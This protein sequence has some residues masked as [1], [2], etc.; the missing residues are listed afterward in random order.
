ML[1]DPSKG[2]SRLLEYRLAQV[3]KPAKEHGVKIITNMGAVNPQAAVAKAVEIA[4]EQGITG[5]KFAA[6]TG[7]SVYETLS[8]YGDEPI[9]EFE[10]KVGQWTDRIVSANAYMGAEGIIEALKNGADVVI[11]GRVSDP[12]LTL[13]PL[14]Y[15]YGWTLDNPEQLGQCVL[16]GHLLECGGQVTGGY[17]ADPGYKEVPDLDN[18]GFPLVEFDETGRFTLT[19]VEGTGGLVSVDTCKEQMLYEIH[20]PAAY[21]IGRAHV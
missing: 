7:D 21:Q 12:T 6:V 11:T 19:K 13:A 10:G 9:L 1:K 16:A 18:L 20:N 14:C 5:L 3:L 2:Y 15:E 4:R 8:R 17:Y